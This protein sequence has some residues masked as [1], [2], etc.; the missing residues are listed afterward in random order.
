[1]LVIIN[2]PTIGR[3]YFDYDDANFT[4]PMSQT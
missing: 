2:P 1:M 4:H 3:L